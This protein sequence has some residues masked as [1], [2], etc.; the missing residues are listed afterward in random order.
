MEGARRLEGSPYL[1]NEEIPH[2]EGGTWGLHNY[3]GELDAL[4]RGSQPGPLDELLLR[5]LREGK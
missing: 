4:H 5:I 2:G 1:A 3:Q